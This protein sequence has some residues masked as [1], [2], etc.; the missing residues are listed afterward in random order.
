MNNESPEHE[1][2]L[3]QLCEKMRKE[4]WVVVPLNRKSPD[5]VASKDGKMVA[6]EVLAKY[7]KER[8]YKLTG[9]TYSAKRRLYEKLGFDSVVFDTVRLD[10]KKAKQ[11]GSGWF[12]KTYNTMNPP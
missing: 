11:N 8:D 5:A 4:G 12:A 10:A 7:G 6:I 2:A 1:I 9:G 3:K